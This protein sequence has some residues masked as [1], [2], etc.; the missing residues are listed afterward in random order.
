MRLEVLQARGYRQPILSSRCQQHAAGRNC[1]RISMI[2]PKRARAT[3][4]LRR[5]GLFQWTVTDDD[6][7]FIF[8]VAGPLRPPH[9]V[10][11]VDAIEQPV[12]AAVYLDSGEGF[13]EAKSL[14][15]RPAGRAVCWLELGKMPDVHRV[16]FDPSTGPGNVRVLALRTGSGFLAR[17]L[18]RY[19]DQDRPGR[20]PTRTFRL[21]SSRV[22]A[23]E[24]GTGR[25]A[26][27]YR[28]TAEHYA[29]V[30]ALAAERP[31]PRGST[32][33]RPLISFL[34]PT[35]ETDPLH[36]ETLLQS[37]Q[38]QPIGLSELIFSD[39]GSKSPATREWLQRHAGTPGVKVMFSKQNQGIAAATNRALNE[40]TTPWI[41]LADH[42]DA[43]S[44]GAVAEI[45]RAIA[46]RPDAQFIYTD[47]VIA[48][49]RMKPVGYMLKPAYDPV[50]LS[51]V[52]YI[53]HLSIYR[54]ERL[55]DVGAFR[56]GFQGSQ[57]YDLLLRYL[58]GISPVQA[59]HVPYPAYV[60]RRH[61]TSF[62]TEFKRVAVESARRA[63]GARY[64]E[65]GRPAQVDAALEPDLHRI[66]F[67]AA[68]K[69]WPKVSVIIPNRDSPE[70][71][72][73]VLRGLTQTDYIDL[74]IVVADNDTHDPATLDLYHRHRQE[75]RPF[76]VQPVPGPFNFSRSINLGVARA[77]GELLLLLNNDIEVE[78]SGWLKEMVSCFRYDETGIVGARLL[79]PDRTIQHAGV[80][81]GLGGLAGHWVGGMSDRIRGPMGRLAV[82][83]SMS[84]V[85]G[86]A[87]LVSRACFEAV[88]PFDENRFAIAYNDIDF[89]LRARAK[90]FR[91]VWTPFATLIH[92]ESASR[93]SD[94]APD[95][96]ERFR[97]EQH[98][99]RERHRSDRL[100]DPAYSP[101]LDTRGSVPGL[102]AL[103]ELPDPR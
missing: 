14:T 60:W 2:T 78:E 43:L 90:G 41:G 20:G 85:T 32:F 73:T 13:S 57:D 39:D 64:A 45:A 22:S 17:R 38:A 40:A 68:M 34:V 49:S 53:N 37:F 55:L 8:T 67:D 88:G 18:V 100:V 29:D 69:R 80:I 3:R 65:E 59:V 76:I 42:D 75:A 99:L 4:G 70:L 86:A 25:D 94:E 89:C 52:N 63:L 54:R 5:R 9:L 97:L 35:Y 56:Q 46:E 36:L 27:R 1:I 62:S 19:L 48:D 84:A 71:M 81:V 10:L 92:H 79:Y 15:F 58:D 31:G 77:S 82:R 61:E 12:E 98:N 91:V 24:L 44:P 33:D 66:R 21:A 11:V 83:Q 23:N 47:E 7:Q 50:L 28:N 6:P 102:R 72:A 95:K 103:D 51:G 87:M 74:E 16:R 93:G 30:L 96:I 26:R 101:W